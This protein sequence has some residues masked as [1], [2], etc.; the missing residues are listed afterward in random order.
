[1][2]GLFFSLDRL[3]EISFNLQSHIISVISFF[4]TDFTVM[5]YSP[6]LYPSPRIYPLN[7]SKNNSREALNANAGTCLFFF[8]PQNTSKKFDHSFEWIKIWIEFSLGFLIE[9]FLLVIEDK[10]SVTSLIYSSSFLLK[11]NPT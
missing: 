9:I 4:E 1:M 3:Q 8:L 10:S 6:I 7:N 11:V 5:P 2:W